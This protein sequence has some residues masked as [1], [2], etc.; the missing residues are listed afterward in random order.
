MKRLALPIL[1]VLLPLPALAQVAT[2]ECAAD[3]GSLA[4]LAD[5][6]RATAF[7]ATAP[8]D[9]QALAK[10]HP[11]YQVVPGTDY[12]ATANALVDSATKSIDIHQF[13]FF[14]EDGATLDFAKKLIAIKAAH[15]EIAIRVALE[16]A[17]DGAKANGVAARN[18][19][20]RKLFEGTG[21][22]TFP[23]HGVDGTE[24][25]SH[26]KVI[27]VDGTKV[28]AGST[29][30]TNTSTQKNNEMNLLVT[31]PAFGCAVSSWLDQVIANPGVAH[32]STTKDGAVT[33]LTDTSYFQTALDTVNGAKKSIDLEMYWVSDKGAKSPEVQALVN[34]LIAK[35]QAKPSIPVR[36]YL[37]RNGNPMISPGVTQQNLAIAK[38]LT[39]AGV[40]V[41]FDPPNKISHAKYLVVDG[42]TTLVGSTNWATGDLDDCHQ[43]NWL[44]KGKTT[45]K[46]MEAFFQQ[47][48][49]TEGTPASQVLGAPAG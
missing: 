2:G 15:P 23:V 3:V 26:A 37:E 19:A 5:V 25:V 8:T 44:V 39:D 43:V 17:K 22:E 47:R 12:L 4:S 35:A 36:V 34:A 13:N 10:G 48:I 11:K 31:S 7:A 18:A 42:S 29:N 28:L 45:A 20:T 16:S 14:T 1:M 21:I 38:Q 33:M 49:D 9:C 24:G 41:W 6:S 46:A 32:P 30:L 40:Q 27:A